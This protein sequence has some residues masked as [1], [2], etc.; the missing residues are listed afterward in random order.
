ML[1]AVALALATW[2]APALTGC[3]PAEQ[4]GPVGIDSALAEGPSSIQ[5]GVR[6]CHGDPE[7]TVL[8]ETADRVEVEVTSTTYRESDDCLDSLVV[9]LAAPLGTRELVDATSGDTVRVTR[10]GS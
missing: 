1:P 10:T 7:V 6:S 9:D 4:R 8:V 2:L 3:T 5:L